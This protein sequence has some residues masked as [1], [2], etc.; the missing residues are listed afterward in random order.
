MKKTKLS[1]TQIINLLKEG[2]SGIGVDE[3]C[4]K[5]G[6]GHN[7]HYKG[8]SKYGGMEVSALKKLKALEEEN[9]RLKELFPKAS[10]ENQI[11]QDIVEEKI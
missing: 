6:I 3:L 2:E 5:H 7:I 4:R 10:L 1:E 9:R 11:L 8:R